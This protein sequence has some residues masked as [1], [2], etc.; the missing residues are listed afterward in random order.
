M[1]H[2]FRS[3]AALALLS[4][5]CSPCSLNAQTSPR[6]DKITSAVMDVYNDELKT[7]PDN[8][9]VLFRRAH[10]FYG[11]GQY[12]QALVDIDR[13]I[14]LIPK[15]DS[16]LLC[17]AY[18]LRAN[19]YLM[20]DRYE[21]A[22]ADLDAAYSLDPTSYTLL[23]QKA[24]T[25][26]LIGR[27]ADAKEDYRRLQRRHNRSLE[28]LIGLA[29]VAVKENNLG[30]ANEYVDEAVALYPAEAE[31][32]I[33]RASVRQLLGNMTGAVDDLILALAVDKN[34][35]HAI[36]EIVKISHIDYNAVISSLSSAISQAPDVGIY[37]YI[38]AS[39]EQAHYHYVPAIN[40]FN[41][42]IN[43]NLYN[44]P[45]L[46][47]SLAE[48]YYALEDYDKAIS[49]INYAIGSTADNAPFYVTLSKIR[50][51]TGNDMNA[52]EAAMMACDKDPQSNAAL[53][54]KGLCAEAQRK[55]ND[56]S[57][58]IGEAILNQP[59]DPR[60][61]II[62]GSILQHDLNR[63]SEA[64]AF[65]QRATE[66]TDYPASINSLKGF[67][68]LALNDIEGAKQWVEQAIE[69]QVDV[70]GRHHFLAACLYS[71]I[72]ETDMALSMAAA[73]LERGYANLYDWRHD[74]TANINIAPLRKDPR[75][76]EL[77]TRYAHLFTL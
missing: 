49:E 66:A 39:I 35:S 64:K 18:S 58:Y 45:G 29:R 37:I 77:L 57:D 5:L 1:K 25:E 11:A 16:D 3:I 53:I 6:A 75:F 7:D 2:I 15:S 20:T 36:S 50:L 40:D 43:R 30:L 54:Q 61:L 73:A 44:F 48:C 34:S 70:D 67:A 38:R 68:L 14:P 60:L 22:L 62:R 19:I 51:A 72:G 47:A 8:Y 69:S 76:E 4:T 17:Q 12:N 46:H 52:M 32:Y 23:Y 33:R 9:N 55:F 24:N 31:A 10:L 41:S 28:A 65:Y 56:A 13:A 21:E 27:Y 59:E 63:P 71:Q 74:E 26:Y 42:I